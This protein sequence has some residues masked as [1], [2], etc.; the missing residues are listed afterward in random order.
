MFI[1]PVV[2]VI[3]VFW[4]GFTNASAQNANDIFRLFGGM[5]Q[6]AII[7]ATLEQWRKIPE[8]QVACVIGS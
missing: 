6:T 1:R 2:L 4:V 3:L 8:R 5:M 7:Q